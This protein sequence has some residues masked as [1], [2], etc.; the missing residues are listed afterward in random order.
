MGVRLY[1]MI[2][3][4]LLLMALWLITSGLLVPLGTPDQAASAHELAV[5]S[6]SFRQYVMLPALVLVT[7][8]FYGY[9]WTRIGQTLGMQTWR[10]KVVRTDGLLPRWQD[11]ITRCAAACIF[12]LV[13]GI[14]TTLAQQDLKTVAISVLAGFFANYLWMLWSPHGMCWHDQLSRT[15]VLRLP[16]PAKDKKRKF[17]G[18]FAEKND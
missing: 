6:E 12:P 10:L 13:C 16:P 17:F 18:W 9:F 7:W 4:G 3:D 5:V 14:V 2:Y 11:A 1:C 15:V 8:L